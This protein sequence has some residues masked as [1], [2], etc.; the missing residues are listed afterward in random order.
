MTDPNPVTVEANHLV[1]AALIEAQTD[2]QSANAM[3]EHAAELYEQADRPD[4]AKDARDLE[5]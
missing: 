5:Q 1:H 2:Q 4:L 3:L